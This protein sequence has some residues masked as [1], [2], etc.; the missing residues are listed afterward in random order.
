MFRKRKAAI[1]YR[2][3]N[4]DSEVRLA[5]IYSPYPSMPFR[6][7]IYRVPV[8]TITSLSQPSPTFQTP[9]KE[10]KHG[11]PIPVFYISLP[12]RLLTAGRQTVNVRQEL[13]L[14]YT[15]IPHEADVDVAW[16]ERKP[17]QLFLMQVTQQQIKIPT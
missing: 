8:P 5:L 2:T 4:G 13:R 10:N 16:K 3:N 1:V 15:R 12:E 7:K 11:D 6:V 14:S 9:K 17:L